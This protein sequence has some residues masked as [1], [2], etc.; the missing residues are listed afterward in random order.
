MLQNA[1]FLAK[2]IGADTADNEQHFAGCATRA[3][4]ECACQDLG[5]KVCGG[6]GFLVLSRALLLRALVAAQLVSKLRPCVHLR[7]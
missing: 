5:A 4:L 7:A 1:Y 2:T 6:V 3:A